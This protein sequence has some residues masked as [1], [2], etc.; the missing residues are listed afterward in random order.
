MVPVG[1]D[2]LLAVFEASSEAIVACVSCLN[3]RLGCAGAEEGLGAM[4]TG[5]LF[6]NWAPKWYAVVRVN[7]MAGCVLMLGGA[8]GE[9]LAIV[10]C[11]GLKSGA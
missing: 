7:A 6:L 5:F 9:L 3:W 10:V 8:I 11:E 4:A 1:L 2:A